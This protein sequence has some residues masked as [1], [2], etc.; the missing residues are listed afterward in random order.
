M[1][2]EFVDYTQLEKARLKAK[3]DWEGGF[4]GMLDYGFPNKIYKLF[5]ELVKISNN[6][7]S[8]HNKIYDYFENKEYAVDD[9]EDGY[10]FDN[11]IENGFFS[12]EVHKEFPNLRVY[13][14]EMSTIEHAIDCYLE[15]D[16]DKRV[17]TDE[18]LD[19][20]DHIFD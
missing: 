15:P 4:Q 12:E 19:T 16:D 20:V 5:P 8:I 1:N 6:L 11:S 18:E 10:E 17:F 14:E 13:E 7:E 3:Y 9:D 2:S